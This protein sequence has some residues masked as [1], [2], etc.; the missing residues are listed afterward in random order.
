LRICGASVGRS[1]YSSYMISWESPEFHYHDKDEAWPAIVVLVGAAVAGFSLWQHNFLFFVFSLI[2]TGLVLVW[3]RRRPRIF[4]FSLGKSGVHIDGRLYPYR[5]FDGFAIGEDVLQ[6]STKSPL[7][8]RFTLIMPDEKVDKVREY[9][10]AFL[11]EIEY[12]ESFIEALGR[13]AR[14]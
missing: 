11:P 4:V 3:G 10:L 6:L 13:W 1:C 8:P 14:L 5:D 9:L 2:A 7:R 12:D